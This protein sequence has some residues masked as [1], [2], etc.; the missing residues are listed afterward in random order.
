MFVCVFSQLSEDLYH[1]GSC[2]CPFADLEVSPGLI[3]NFS[4]FLPSNMIAAWKEPQ[5]DVDS[6][7]VLWP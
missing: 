1:T 7:P 2:W 5:L 4:K 3:F 6:I